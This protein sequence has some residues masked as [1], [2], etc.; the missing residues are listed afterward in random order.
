ML[1]IFS[2]GVFT[3]TQ[4]LKKSSTI[5]SRLVEKVNESKRY[6]KN[7]TNGLLF[8]GYMNNR[9]EVDYVHHLSLLEGNEFQAEIEKLLNNTF[10]D[11]QTII[12][13]SGDG[14]TDGLYDGNTILCCCYGLKT[15][16]KK[17]SDADKKQKVIIK[18]TNDIKRVLEMRTSGRGKNKKYEHSENN[19][20]GDIL[21]ERIKIK[22]LTLIVNYYDNS[23]IGRLNDIFDELKQKS[24][25]NFISP[26]CTLVIHGPEK[27]YSLCNITENDLVR[28]KYKKILSILEMAV[29]AD[30]PVDLLEQSDLKEYEEKIKYLEEN[31]CDTEEK[32]QTLVDY[33]NDNLEAWCRYIIFMQKLKKEA[34]RIFEKAI[35]Q[36]NNV[37]KEMK[38]L[39]FG[40]TLDPYEKIEKF[41]EKLK[42]K[43]VKIFDNNENDK[44]QDIINMDCAN[45][46]GT[47]PLDWRDNRK[48][49][50]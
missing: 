36:G 39:I 41:E 3:H 42:D 22:Q 27:I 31:F 45:L 25:L 23:L 19:I 6:S 48:K 11:F 4:T 8:G 34:P 49:S 14:G 32:R 40:K 10:W 9:I 7:V 18:F 35:I 2:D 13:D 1:L 12:G 29:S 5:S 46:I 33:K 28:L 44:I 38:N 24:Q 16:G 17:L 50:A 20:L 43:W 47:C 15:V 26:K 37:L 21:G 30:R